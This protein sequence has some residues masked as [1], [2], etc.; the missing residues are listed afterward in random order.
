MTNEQKK[1]AAKVLVALATYNEIEN[2]PKLVKEI[3]TLTPDV[4]VLIVDDNSPDGTG[5]WALDAAEKD[6][7][8]HA[9]IRT[10]ERGLGSAVIRAFKYAIENDYD[11]LVNMDADFSHP[12]DV[13]PEM[14]K[15][16]ETESPQVDVVIGSRYVPGGATPDW[17]LRRKIMSRCVNLFARVALGLKTKDNSGSFRR[18]RVEAL[19][20]LD[21]DRFVSTGYSFF[22]E[23]LFRL[24]RAGA[25]FAEIPIVFVDRK[26]GASK[27]NKKEAIKAV[28]IITTLGLKRLLCCEGAIKK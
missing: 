14:L 16:I 7:R 8:I 24:Q 6:P 11:Y 1:P 9:L 17:P 5:R 3:L 18:Y 27:I 4:D 19:K 2:L 21:F 22:E 10:N 15:T 20:T 25:T 12:V 28:W 13:V 23:T 26:R